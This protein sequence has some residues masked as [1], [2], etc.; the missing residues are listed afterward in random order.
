MP[1][2]VQVERA[3]SGGLLGAMWIIEGLGE[4]MAANW[5]ERIE[6]LTGCGSEAT[7]F[8]RITVTTMMRT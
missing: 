6:S 5:A 4:K 2:C 8:L 1:F 7:R 3:Q